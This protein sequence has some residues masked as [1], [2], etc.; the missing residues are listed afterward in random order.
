LLLTPQLIGASHP[1]PNSSPIRVAADF[2]GAD[3]GE[4]LN[5]AYAD[6][7]E[8]GGQISITAGGSFAKPIVFGTN[9]K[10]VLMIGIPGDVVNLIYT[11][12]SGTAI[13]FDYGTGHRMGHGLRDVTLTGP[14]D[15]TNTVGVRFGGNN[16]AEGLAFRDFKIQSFGKNLEM[17]S[18]VWLAYFEHGLI[19]D[20]GMNVFLPAGL[21]EAGE[22]IVFQSRHFRGCSTSP[23]EQRLDTRWW[24][25]GDLSRLLVRSGSIAN[26]Q[27]RSGRGPSGRE[28][29]PFREPEL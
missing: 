23:C 7:P 5:A 18:H 24:A 28:R 26:R 10:P 13:T 17:G 16:G 9:N 25:R 1:T 21:A 27:R 8:Q 20:G 6:L 29:I 12:T 14:G 19:R 3:V 4:Q 22:Q 11:G 15:A 2:P